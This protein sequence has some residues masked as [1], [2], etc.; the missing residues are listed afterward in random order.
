M[1]TYVFCFFTWRP[2]YVVLLIA[3][4]LFLNVD[5]S[6]HGVENSLVEQR[7]PIFFSAFNV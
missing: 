5:G 7:I 4:L 1:F 6:K 2:C 3:S